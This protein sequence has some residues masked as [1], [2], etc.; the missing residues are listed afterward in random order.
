MVAT[1][2]GGGRSLTL[3]PWGFRPSLT[4]ICSTRM[5]AVSSWNARC[6]TGLLWLGCAVFACTVARRRWVGVFLALGDFGVFFCVLFYLVSSFLDYSDVLYYC[7]AKV[8]FFRSWFAWWSC[9]SACSKTQPA[10]FLG[11]VA[12]VSL[13]PQLFLVRCT[14]TCGVRCCCRNSSSLQ[15]TL[16][17]ACLR[18]AW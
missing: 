8:L 14:H 1:R 11:A 18:V 6:G 7:W 13:C 9:C 3:S 15:T 2:G 10:V 16:N 4:R 5:L 17:D 12:K